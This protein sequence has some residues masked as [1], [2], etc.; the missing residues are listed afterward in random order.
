MKPVIRL[1]KLQSGAE[2]ALRGG[3]G[4]DAPN[5]AKRAFSS[6]KLRREAQRA[7]KKAEVKR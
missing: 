6:R 2:L 4:W 5:H 3:L 7:M 1:L